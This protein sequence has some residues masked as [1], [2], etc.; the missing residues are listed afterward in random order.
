MAPTDNAVDSALFR[1][2]KYDAVSHPSTIFSL[3]LFS[4]VKELWNNLFDNI[5]NLALSSGMMCHN[6]YHFQLF[7]VLSASGLGALR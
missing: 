3:L 4:L 7:S 6:I 5:I 2:L 1:I